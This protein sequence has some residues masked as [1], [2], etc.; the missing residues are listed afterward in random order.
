M[1]TSRI[2]FK[3]EDLHIAGFCLDYLN[4]GCFDANLTDTEIQQFHGEGYY[5]FEDYAIAHW[6][7]H[8]ETSTSQLLPLHATSLD[9]L[10]NGLELFIMKHG[11]ESPPDV[12]VSAGQGFQSIKECTFIKR[13][14]DLS[15]LAHQRQ[16]NEQHLDLETQ[17]QRRRLIYEDMITNINPIGEVSQDPVLL[18]RSGRFKCP[19][20]WCQF[21]SEGFQQKERRD[22]HIN[23]HERP[24]RCSFEDCLYK[25][26]GFGTEKELKRH[27]KSHPTIQGSEWAF[28]TLKPKKQ[29]DIFSA[30]KKGDL[31]TLRR[32]V[33]EGADI[34]KKTRPN[35]VVT[36]LYLAVKHNH[37]DVVKYLIEQGDH[38]NLYSISSIIFLAVKNCSSDIIQMLLDMEGGPIS[39][40][41]TAQKGLEAAAVIGRTDVVPLFLACRININ[42]N[43]RS[44]TALRIAREMGHDAFVQVL[45]EN[46]AQALLDDG[47]LVSQDN[48]A[49]DETSVPTPTPATP[50]TPQGISPS[51]LNSTDIL[52]SFNF[53]QFLQDNADDIKQFLESSN[54]SGH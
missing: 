18:D 7:A 30:S 11:F 20:I 37:S 1:K 54:I 49:R 50:V 27:G 51:E 8:V 53:E 15:H 32:L 46:G 44:G 23:Q 9:H 45:L 33:G 52:K 39:K 3:S 29:L 31:A 40:I 48:N 38:H 34:N 25:Q 22:K 42:H 41:D 17:L 36:P 13:L 35:G 5:A 43:Y 26:L 2:S 6:L 4:F 10:K 19:R 28:P 47:T 16:S 14:E 24:F 12:S 21:F